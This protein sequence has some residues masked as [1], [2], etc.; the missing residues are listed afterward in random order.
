MNIVKIILD[1]KGRFETK[2]TAVPYRSGFDKELARKY[3]LECGY[4]IQFTT[5]PEINFR[6]EALKDQVF[7]YC[8]SEDQD[9]FYKSYIEDMVLGLKLAGAIVIPDYI[10]LKAHNNKLFME[11]L[12]DINCQNELQ[13]ITSHYFGTLEDLKLNNEFFKNALFVIK[14]AM[15][16]MSKGV[17]AGSN[18]N[19]IYSHSK[20]ISKASFH[21]EEIKD[22]LRKFKHK[23]YKTD[24]KFRK[25]FI[26]QNMIEGLEGDWKILVY[27]DKYYPLKRKN[28]KDDF[29]ASGGGLLSYEK[30]LPKGLLSFAK[31]VYESFNVPNLSIDIGFNGND[32]FLIEFQALYFGTYTIEKSEFYFIQGE[33]KWEI[34]E[35]RSILEKEYARSV[36]AFISKTSK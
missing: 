20:N 5:F 15:G 25:K 29:R 11:I 33:N 28:R 27:G 23:G 18:F 12:R 32:F 8:S 10:Y 30:V 9:G 14:P 7:L 24:S 6:D 34:R 19:E 1:Y 16:A 21:W 4:E 36:S 31:T 3:F 26:I 17:S 13:N 35:E 2:Y 22:Y